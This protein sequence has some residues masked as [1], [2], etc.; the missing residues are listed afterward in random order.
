MIVEKSFPIKTEFSPIQDTTPFA[1][2]L[3]F[4]KLLSDGKILHRLPGERLRSQGWLDGQMVLAVMLLNLL[5]FDPVSDIDRL[6]EDRVLCRMVGKIEPH[7]FGCIRRT[8]DGR[9]RGGRKRTFPSPRSIRDWLERCHDEAAGKRRV[10]G[11]AWIPPPSVALKRLHRINGAM[12]HRQVRRKNLTHLTIDIDATIIRSGKRE[13]LSTYRAANGSVP[14]ERGYQ[15]LMGYCLELGMILHVEMR[16]GN[17]AASAGNCRFRDEILHMLPDQV[18]SVSVRMDSA[19][20]P[21][22]VIRY[23]NDPSVRDEPV[24][25]FG[26]IG[27]VLGARLCDSSLDSIASTEGG[28]WQPGV[29]DCEGW[30]GAEICHVPAMVAGMPKGHRV[31]YV[32][33]RHGIGELGVGTDELGGGHWDGV[34]PCRLRLLATNHPSPDEDDTDDASLPVRDMWEVRAE[35]NA[36]CGDSEQAHG[37]M[38]SD[39]AGGMVPSGRFGANGCWVFLSCLRHNLVLIGRE[40][41]VAG[42]RWMR[43]RMKAFRAAFLYRS[44]RLVCHANRLVRKVPV[45]GNGRWEEGWNKRFKLR[46]CSCRLSDRHRPPK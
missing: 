5:G 19:G 7:L 39:F 32:A 17:G 23:C 38:K 37:I 46:V 42:T 30:H 24:R 16:D 21:H 34:G 6:E 12:I 14:F 11:E 44:G 15:P 25:R 45:T 8:L 31:R 40:W 13:C 29:G 4:L 33:F 27:F 3:P 28:D 20:Y 35:A 10:R 26:L 18:T 2:I 22:E 43:V 9:H 41:M 36:R 1:G